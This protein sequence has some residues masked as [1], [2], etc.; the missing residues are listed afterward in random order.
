MNPLELRRRLLIAE[1]GI[2]RTQMI[3]DCVELAA[4]VRLVAAR[5]RSFGSLLTSAQVLFTA[6]A[7]FQSGRFSAGSGPVS[8]FRAVLKGAG[9]VS[10]VW[11]TLQ[12][13]RR[14]PPTPG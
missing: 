2:N 5:A 13:L 11:L 1:S 10:T 7:A 8:W 12:K 14:R 3:E 4:G 9:L 6:T